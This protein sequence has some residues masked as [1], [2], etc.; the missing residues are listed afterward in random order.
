MWPPAL[1]L[2]CPIW[3]TL[4]KSANLSEPV[5]HLSNELAGILGGWRAGWGWDS[6]CRG[7]HTALPSNGVC[8]PRGSML[9]SQPKMQT[10]WGA[11]W[12]DGNGALSGTEVCF[13]RMSVLKKGLW[14]AAGLAWRQDSFFPE[15]QEST[16]LG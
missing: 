2:L 13:L 10:V 1:A 15:R 6:K 12:G 7:L 3:L 9:A 5:S 16:H 8:H 4:G 14:M 11:A